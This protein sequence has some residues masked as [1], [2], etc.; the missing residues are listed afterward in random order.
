[1]SDLVIDV[2]NLG[3]MYRIGALQERSDTLRDAITDGTRN[4]FRRNLNPGGTEEFWAVRDVNFQVER[5]EVLGIIGRNGAGKSTLL[6]L[7]SRITTPTEGE[8]R[9]RGRVGTLLEVGTGF[10][11]E[12]SGRENIYMNGAILGMT[13]QEINSKFDEI[14]T[15]SEIEKFIDTPVKRYSSGMYIRLAF[16]VAAHLES[17]ILLVDEVLAVGDVAFQRKCLGKMDDIAEGGRTVVFVS[18]NMATIQ[19]MCKRGI[20]MDAGQIAYNGDIDSAVETYLTMVEEHIDTTELYYR[21]DRFGGELFRYSAVQFFDT[22]TGLPVNSLLSG[23]D[24]TIKLQYDCR[25]PEGLQDV[26]VTMAFFKQGEIFLFACRSD[27]VEQH[28]NIS[29]G[30]GEVTCRIPRWPVNQGRV[31]FN[32]NAISRNGHVDRVRNAGYID[33]EMGDFYGSGKLP[34]VT[35]Q[36]VLIDFAFLPQLTG[37]TVDLD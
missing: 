10:H 4:M 21:T 37:K 35:R 28:Y 23:Q 7:L 16:S 19:S 15:F 9:V 25:V 26:S 13:R 29:F 11:P 12:L 5:G 34:A 30:P 2:R 20:V 32:I 22:N 6:K 24:V 33:T 17:D 27:V 31:M 36:G 18:H 1:M 14:V 8:I 3:K